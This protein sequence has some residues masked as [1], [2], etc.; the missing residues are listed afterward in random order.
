MR[1]A[2]LSAAFAVQFS[3]FLFGDSWPCFRLSLSPISAQ[4]E[5]YLRLKDIMKS[6]VT[7]NLLLADIHDY[8]QDFHDYVIQNEVF[9]ILTRFGPKL[10][11]VRFSLNFDPI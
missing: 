4:L 8:W 5:I 3:F 7:S 6:Y 2:S 9:A 10:M 11:F 1:A